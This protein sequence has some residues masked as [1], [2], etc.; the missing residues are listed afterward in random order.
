MT[1]LASAD[2][3]QPLSLKYHIKV[4][5]GKAR[6]WQI[7]NGQP[8]RKGQRT[9]QRSG[10]GR[11]GGKNKVYKR[12]HSV[13]EGVGSVGKNKTKHIRD[14]TEFRRGSGRGHYTPFVS[15]RFQ[16]PTTYYHNTHYPLTTPQK[17]HADPLHPLRQHRHTCQTNPN[18]GTKA[19]PQ[20]AQLL[21]QLNRTHV[22]LYPHYRISLPLLFSTVISEGY[23]RWLTRVISG[24]GTECAHGRPLPPPQQKEAPTEIIWYGGRR[25]AKAGVRAQRVL[26]SRPDLVAATPYVPP[27]SPSSHMCPAPCLNTLRGHLT[28]TATPLLHIAPPSQSYYPSLILTLPFPHSYTHSLSCWALVHAHTDT[29]SP[30]YSPS[31]TLTMSLPHPHNFT[32]PPSPSPCFFTLTLP[33]PHPHNTLF[34]HPDCLSLITHPHPSHSTLQLPAPT[35]PS[36]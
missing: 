29:P 20:S 21:Q 28:S 11:V 18:V 25:Q 15:Q 4:Q 36:L 24:H 12:H 10:G 19:P 14:R 16:P 22:Q 27:P 7:I 26:S 32:D 33:L 30:S 13:Q 9:P 3:H 31:L 17:Q 2:T 23:E 5:L 1:G 35:S 34:L 8:T 6:L